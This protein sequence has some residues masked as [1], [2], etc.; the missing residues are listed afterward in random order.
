[1]LWEDQPNSRCFSFSGGHLT[2]YLIILCTKVSRYDDISKDRYLAGCFFEHC[3]RGIS[4]EIQQK[5]FIV[6]YYL[7]ICK[8]NVLYVCTYIANT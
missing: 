5:A 7:G 8:P 6:Y 2:V 1:M 4:R 3:R